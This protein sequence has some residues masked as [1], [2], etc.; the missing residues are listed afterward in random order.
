M[1]IIY[2]DKCLEYNGRPESPE[3]VKKTY[4]LLEEKGYQFT[5]PEPASEEQIQQVHTENHIKKIE[6]GDFFDMDTPAWNNIYEFAKLS[7]G[8]AVKA[9]EVEGF[10][11][12]RPPGHHAGENGT[13]LGAPTLGFCYFNNIAIAVAD[14]DEKTLIID[15]DGHHGNG[16]QE[17]FQGSDSVVYLSLHRYPHYPGTGTESKDNYI[18]YPLSGDTRDEKYLEKLDEGIERALEM[19][20]YEQVAVSAGFDSYDNDLASL[21]LS[22]SCFAEI[23]ERIGELGKPTF[24]V[25]EGGYG[26]ISRRV[27]NFLTGLESA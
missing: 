2:T 10:S 13:A 7:A 4:Q 5:E 12:M 9:Q 20:N 14:S 27:Y 24:V 19:Q 15:I 22:E 6:S 25:L 11:L 21:A 8:G 1:K 17:I 18:N 26:D 16:T 3:R 23:G